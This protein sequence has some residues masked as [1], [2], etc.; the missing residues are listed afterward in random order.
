MD[1]FMLGLLSMTAAQQPQQFAQAMSQ[2][3]VSPQGFSG[4]NTQDPLGS[5]I[6]GQGMA[7]PAGGAQPTLDGWGATVT[8]SA[9][10]APQA[11][12]PL[13]GNMLSSLQGMKLPS[14]PQPIMSAGVSGSQNVPKPGAMPG[15]GALASAI[16]QLIG[17]GGMPDPLRVPALGSLIQRG[18]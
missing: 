8:P 14:P 15:N 13:P 2:F 1:P 16:M 6:T 5:L 4:M 12:P 17:G 9:S 18:V 10:Q 11:S 3:G 7:P